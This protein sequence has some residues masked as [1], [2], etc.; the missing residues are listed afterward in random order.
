MEMNAA[1]P[2]SNRTAPSCKARLMVVTISGVN[3]VL[4]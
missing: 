1:C 2:E 3:G 4:G